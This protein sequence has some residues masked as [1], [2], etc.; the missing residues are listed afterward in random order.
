MTA[1]T[2]DTTNPDDTSAVNGDTTI[3]DDATVVDDPAPSR[4]ATRRRRRPRWWRD[5]RRAILAAAVVMVLVTASSVLS[6]LTAPGTDSVAAR[7]AEWARGHGLSGIV[8]WAENEQY[9]RNKPVVGG[10]LNAGQRAQL[11]SGPTPSPAANLP[12]PITPTVLPALAGEGAWHVLTQVS[13]QPIVMRAVLRPDPAHTSYLAYVGWIN[14]SHVRF[15]LHPGTQEPGHGPWQE[16]ATLPTSHRS[17]LVA[18]FNSGF[19]LSDALMGPY[20]GYYADKKTVGRLRNG[21]AAMI[22]HTDG[23]MTIG[24][25]GRDGSLNDPTI[26]AVRENLHLLVDNGQVQADA[27]DG[28]GQTWGYTVKNAYYVWRS[29][30]GVTAD[31]NIVYAIGATLSVQSL[32]EVLQRAG[33]VRAMEL[34]INPDWVSFMTYTTASAT[35]TKLANFN[36]PADRYYH[37]SSRDFVAVYLR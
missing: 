32:A 23:S 15:E 20:G 3:V 25:W 22:F 6:A 11:Q 27:M 33:A 14:T 19:R 17:G 8:T 13:N 28:S 35:P 5:T 30:V 37:T 29:G 26:T 12:A 2:G 16:P 18:T 31:G 10:T 7:L 4:G 36:K 1:P 21:D 34:D 9:Q 24:T